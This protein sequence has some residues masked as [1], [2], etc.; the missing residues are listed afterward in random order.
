ML[1]VTKALSMGEVGDGS[2]T[3]LIA[4]NSDEGTH[5][6]LANK[7]TT[8]RNLTHSRKLAHKYMIHSN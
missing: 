7:K 6:A 3:P 5:I 2:V 4:N 8:Q 1:H